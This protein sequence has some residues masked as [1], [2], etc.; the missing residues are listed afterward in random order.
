MR[1]AIQDAVDSKTIVKAVF[2]PS[3]G[4]ASSVV[5]SNTPGY[6]NESK[7]LSYDPAKAEKLLE[8]DGWVVGSGGYRYKD[9]TELTLRVP[10]IAAWGGST[11]LQAE[12]K[13]VGINLPLDSSDQ[14]TQAADLASG[15]YDLDKWQMTRSD[16]SVLYA[17]W[18]STHTSQGYARAN[19]SPLDKLLN[20]QEAATDPA[21][22]TADAAK[23]QQY[24]I[25]NDWAIPLDDRAWTY[26]YNS[27]AHGLRIDGETKLDFYNVWVGK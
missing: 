3:Y 22:R 24:L 17:V 11:L 2:G 27:S 1:A 21:V 26:A 7:Y 20:A 5:G 19:P 9:G 10:G 13:A 14:A 15:A 12:L 16:P 8:A 4:P 6:A 25:Q 23:V 18:S